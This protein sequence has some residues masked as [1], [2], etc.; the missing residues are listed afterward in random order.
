MDMTISSCHQWIND[1]DPSHMPVVVTLPLKFQAALHQ[2]VVEMEERLSPA[3]RDLEIKREEVHVSRLLRP[4]EFSFESES[5]F[6][7]P[8][9]H[10]LLKA[11]IDEELSEAELCDEIVSSFMT[12][13]EVA[14][15]EDSPDTPS[16]DAAVESSLERPRRPML[17][18][19]I[20]DV[21]PR[22]FSYLTAETLRLRR[23]L[24]ELIV[25]RERIVRPCRVDRLVQE[26]WRARL[27][28]V[29]FGRDFLVT[30]LKGW[31][32]LTLFII[33]WLQFSAAR[34]MQNVPAMFFQNVAESLGMQGVLPPVVTEHPLDTEVLADLGYM[35]V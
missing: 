8:S 32:D 18:L 2:L 16:E 17:P 6:V 4:N 13:F 7:D 9:Q 26:V 33:K 21:W 10:Q 24:S 30:C 25:E 27:G 5:R 34:G 28:S 20:H 14:F 1:I 35:V 19:E 3:Q 11:I 15:G 22:V 23:R 31:P 29:V 12:P